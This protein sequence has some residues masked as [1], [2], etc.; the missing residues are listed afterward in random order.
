MSTSVEMSSS[1]MATSQHIRL[2]RQLGYRASAAPNVL[3]STLSGPQNLSSADPE[4]VIE[5]EK[6]E[7]KVEYKVRGVYVFCQS[8]NICCF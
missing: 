7:V 3:A 5:V 6:S 8:N 1:R 2:Q 4:S